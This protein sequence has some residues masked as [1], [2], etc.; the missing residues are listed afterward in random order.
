MWSLSKTEGKNEKMHLLYSPTNALSLTDQHI[1][2]MGLNHPEC[3]LFGFNLS[4][5]CFTNVF[6]MRVFCAERYKVLKMISL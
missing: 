6:L 1:E 2:A 5:I 4:V 3:T